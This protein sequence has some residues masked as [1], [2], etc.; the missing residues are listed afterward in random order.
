M[1]RRDGEAKQKI[2]DE[3][4]LLYDENGEDSGQEGDSEYRSSQEVQGGQ[5]GTLS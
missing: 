5:A 3:R 4:C 2:G 1:G